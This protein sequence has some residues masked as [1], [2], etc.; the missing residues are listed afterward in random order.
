MEHYARDMMQQS[1]LPR[2]VED[3]VGDERSGVPRTPTFFINGALYR[4]SWEREALLAALKVASRT[5]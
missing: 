3:V 1:P 4:G 2:I 5:A